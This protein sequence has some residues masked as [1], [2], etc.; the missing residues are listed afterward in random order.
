MVPAAKIAEKRS[1]A[2]FKDTAALF[3]DQH[4]STKR[5]P[6][7]AE[8]YRALLN[9]HALP[10]FG[11]RKIETITTSEVARLHNQLKER[12][13]QANRLLAVIS[14]LYSFAESQGLVPEGIQSSKEGRKVSGASTRALPHRRRVGAG[15]IR[16]AGG[17]DRR[18]RLVA[19][20]RRA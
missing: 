17:R 13:Y 18:D 9:A 7:T 1:S 19:R 15:R 8:G 11:N 3:I 20:R 4:V 5:K 12:P 10:S 2:T 16:F 14:S 6:T